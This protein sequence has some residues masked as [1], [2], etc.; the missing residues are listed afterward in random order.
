MGLADALI[1]R[2]DKLIR[3]RLDAAIS[4]R[5]AA[6]DYIAPDNVGIGGIKAKTDLI[7]T[8]GPASA[9]NYTATRAAALDLL[10]AAISLVKAKTDLIPAGGPLAAGSYVAPD[11]TGIAIIEAKTN[12]IPDGG[13]PSATNY[14]AVRALKLDNV[15]VASSVIKAKTDLI[16]AAGP[17]SATDYSAA[18]AA[19]L[20]TAD[21]AS[22]WAAASRTL[23]SGPSQI[24]SFQTGYT[25]ANGTA[26]SG[27]D[28][29]YIDVTISAV[30]TDKCLLQ[31]T[32]RWW[33]PDVGEKGAEKLTAR[34]T[35]ST[36]LRISSN[37][38]SPY[39]T[40]LRWSVLEFV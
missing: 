28:A 36:N 35:S 40:S 27:E 7:P 24:K 30:A 6:S 23:T 34:L 21:A 12:L 14:T 3:D 33:E 22:I 18:R 13:P 25:T 20:D 39:A 5:L 9:G 11:N 29:R 26:G 19:K 37:V 8:A 32:G 4:S 31:V 16:P 17:P 1:A 2:I 15:D 10:D 38:L